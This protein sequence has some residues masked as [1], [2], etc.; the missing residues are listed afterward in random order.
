LL[1][2]IRTLME[3]S[4]LW[5]MNPVYGPRNDNS[6]YSTRVYLWIGILIQEVAL[7]LLPICVDVCTQFF[8]IWKNAIYSSTFRKD[9]MNVTVGKLVTLLD[10]ARFRRIKSPKIAQ[11]ILPSIFCQGC[12]LNRKI[13]IQIVPWLQSLYWL[14]F[15]TSACMPR[16]YDNTVSLMT[17]FK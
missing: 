9:N 10:G 6:R 5:N 2:P 1:K 8:D 7:S 12:V 11:P 14:L 15:H 17:S 13:D 16:C 4:T 3:Q